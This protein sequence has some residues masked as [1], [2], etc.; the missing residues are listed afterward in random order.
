MFRFE[1]IEHLYAFAIIPVLVLFFLLMWYARQRAIRQFGDFQLMKRL[2]PEMSKYKHGIKFAILMVA[3]SFMIIGWANPQWGTKKEKVKRKS[4]DVFIALDISQSMLAEDIS[5][6]RLERAKKFS[7]KL[8]NEL[9]GE[10]IGIIIFAGNAYLQMPLTT[11]YAA[12]ELF[13]RSANIR[14][15]PTQGTAI[16]EAIDLAERSFEQNNKQH[17]AL[18]IITDGENHDQVAIERAKQANENGLLIFTVG[19]GTEEGAYIPTIYAGQRGVK[20][21]K[22]GNP[23]RS[24]INELMLNDLA[25]AGEGVY[26]NLVDGDKVV[27]VLQERIDKVEKREFEQRSFNEFES[28]FQY[29]LAVGFFLILLEFFVSYRKSKWL[30]GKDLF[31]T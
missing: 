25:S 3:L 29:F 30:E 22:T 18:I 5:P 10:R 21:D 15:A 23:V 19:V 8:I 9:K 6:N 24:K 13:V 16:S 2:M 12:A 28:Y 11:D 27:G 4:V 14:Q 20:R 7:Q 26:Y 17:K 31:K 1:N